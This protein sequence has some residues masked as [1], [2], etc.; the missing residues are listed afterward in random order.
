MLFNRD[1]KWTGGL[2]GVKKS[3]RWPPFAHGRS[4]EIC[5]NGEI[6]LTLEQTSPRIRTAPIRPRDGRTH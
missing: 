4:A 3:A 2:G 6:S 5:L 1:A